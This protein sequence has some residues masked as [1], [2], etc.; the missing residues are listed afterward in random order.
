MIFPETTPSVEFN[1]NRK[2]VPANLEVNSWDVLAPYFDELASREIRNST[3]LRNWLLNKSELESVIQEDVAWR[4]IRM[5]CDTTSKEFHDSFNSF[6]SDIEP[7]IAPF[8]NK[9]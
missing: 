1:K 8:T 2:F 5:S 9:L 6:V 4:Y 3:D 7:K